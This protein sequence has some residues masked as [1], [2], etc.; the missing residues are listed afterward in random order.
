MT[1]LQIKICFTKQIENTLNDNTLLGYKVYILK[2]DFFNKFSL[3]EYKPFIGDCLKG[4]LNDYILT[5]DEKKSLK[6]LLNKKSN[7]FLKKLFQIKLII[8]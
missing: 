1:V 3:I 5:T 6:Y 4:I 8:F 7:F 2:V